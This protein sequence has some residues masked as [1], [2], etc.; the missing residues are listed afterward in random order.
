MG[1]DLVKHSLLEIF[2]QM[3]QSLEFIISPC[4]LDP[5]T[6]FE[7][8]TGNYLER[9]I[10]PRALSPVVAPLGLEF[11]YHNPSLPLDYCCSLFWG[12]N[13][14]VIDTLPESIYL[15]CIQ[16]SCLRLSNSFLARV[17]QPSI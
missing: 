7:N 9:E 16:T 15:P 3:S 6:L 8:A 11:S 1:F 2:G 12:N 4:R 17:M 13:Q 10:V 14:R 5:R